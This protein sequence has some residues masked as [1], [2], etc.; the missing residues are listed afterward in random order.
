MQQHARK[1]LERA[2]IIQHSGFTL[3]RAEKHSQD[4]C[5]MAADRALSASA[6]VLCDASPALRPEVEQPLQLRPLWLTQSHLAVDAMD[7]LLI[8]MDKRRELTLFLFPL[9]P[10]RPATF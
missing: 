10:T 7:H 4:L 9:R 1:A 5:L 2:G 8:N 6:T 3:V